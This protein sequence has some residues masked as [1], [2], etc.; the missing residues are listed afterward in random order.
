MMHK[1][2]CYVCRLALHSL[3]NLKLLHNYFIVDFSFLN[4]VV[5]NPKYV[6]HTDCIPFSTKTKWRWQINYINNP[7]IHHF[8]FVI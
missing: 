2:D 3:S 7:K 8:V 6:I 1:D 4:L 5:T